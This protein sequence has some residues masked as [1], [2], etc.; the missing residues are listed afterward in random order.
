MVCEIVIFIEIPVSV[1]VN[2]YNPA[3]E[4]GE[5]PL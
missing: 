1:S 2:E 5:R 3:S 4:R